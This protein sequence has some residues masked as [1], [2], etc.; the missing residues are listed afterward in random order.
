MLGRF[1]GYEIVGVIG[2]GGMG[3][4]L[5]GFEPS[6]NRYV[7]IK[8]L[9]PILASS[10]AARKRFAREAKATAAVLHDN[11]IPIHRVDEAND[12]PYLVMPYLSAPAGKLP[13]DGSRRILTRHRHPPDFGP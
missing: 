4:V 3:V 10:G 12:L 5:K 8:V 2:Q 11:V 6:L 9:A 1:G 7:A 13:D